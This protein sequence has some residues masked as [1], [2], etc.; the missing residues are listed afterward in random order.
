[1]HFCSAS[2][3][4]N[5]DAWMSVAEHTACVCVCVSECHVLKDVCSWTCSWGALVGGGGL[6]HP[7]SC[8]GE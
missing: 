3:I 7:T 5:N 4:L 8:I 1:M 6:W 2:D